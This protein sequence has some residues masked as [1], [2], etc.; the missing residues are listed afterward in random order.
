MRPLPTSS[1]LPLILPLVGAAAPAAADAGDSLTP[2]DRPGLHQAFQTALRTAR[3]DGD[4]FRM[5]SRAS[6]LAARLDG[7][8]L[9]VQD[10]GGAWTWGLELEGFG[11]EGATRSVER[12][13]ATDAQGDR[14]HYR[15]TEDLDEW[16]VNDTGG[17]EHGYTLRARPA[18]PSGASE[19]C[20]AMNVT[21]DLVPRIAGT[22]R[23][24]TFL[25]HSGAAALTYTGLVVFDAEGDELPA[26]IERRGDDLLLRIDER[27]ATY[28][29]TIDPI[30]QTTYLKASNA[31]AHDTFGWAVAMSGDTVAISA[32]GED[33]GSAGIGG[34]GSD[35]GIAGSG[36]VYVFV[37]KG[38]TWAEQA[39]IKSSNPDVFDH[40]G[41]D[42]DLSG[43]TLVV[44]AP[45]E[46]S[47]A[48][49][50][51]G[52][53]ADDSA[54][55]SGAAYVFHR[56]GETW[57]QE[58]YLK[59]PNAES[60]DIFGTAV[61]VSGDLVVVGAPGEA[62]SATGIQGDASDNGTPGAGAAY[63]FARS[64]ST[65][66]SQL[67]LKASNPGV[68]DGF[69]RAVAIE[70]DLVLV[71]APDEDSGSGGPAADP[72]DDSV[73]GAGAV[74]G[75]RRAG[76]LWLTDGYLKPTY[77][78]VSDS[79]GG[80]L[81]ISGT[82]A[83]IGARWEDGGSTG[84]GGDESDDTGDSSGAAFVFE[85][86][87]SAWSQAAYLKASNT[88]PFDSF[89]RSV[90]I[91]GDR[92]VVS[93]TNERSNAVG[94]DGDQ[95]DQSLVGA[96][97]VFAFRRTGGVW[98]QEAYL[99]ASNT[100]GH[101]FFGQGVAITGGTLVASAYW[102]D[103][104]AT[105]IDGDQTDGSAP[106][107]GAAYVFE[108]DSTCGATAY[109]PGTGVNIGKLWSYSAPVEGGQYVFELSDFQAPGLAFLMVS[110][111]PADIP[112]LG[113]TILVDPALSLFG[114]NGV[115]LLL[116]PGTKTTFAAPILQGMGGVTFYAQ[117]GMFDPAMPAG[118]A[119]TN[120]MKIQICP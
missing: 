110:A 24:V 62:S 104:V 54:V 120:G 16:Y 5:V 60:S 89:G 13:L 113:G 32:V 8:G 88:S 21:G 85:H 70:G 37:R 102:E 117:G 55:G 10:P 28:P 39:Y 66:S 99:K 65:W 108:L 4:G 78:G 48:T 105:G 2:E 35:N 3:P 34:D 79:F 111:A 116:L 95:T 86:D 51:D 11:F 7:R 75:F 119:L 68:D 118:V 64:G 31:G 96:G 44:G 33:G 50:V 92:L 47:A 91:S 36:A 103:S 14:V 22:G 77:T 98:A 93:A 30:V 52:D 9:G 26:R 17:L 23:D 72:A 58:A 63:L 6:G 81:A 27:E 115:I 45:G 101:D 69:G 114:P 80:A 71:G 76:E 74:Y 29:L 100:E 18:N 19:L 67:Y 61:A 42:L 49:V 56:S 12:P 53:Q 107:A 59:A 106:Q 38:T 83:V 90:A 46:D 112:A 109:G 97:A 82:T 94:V 73:F 20:F 41:W 87:G 15:W 40:F 57:S 25:D 1:L 43:D 84:V